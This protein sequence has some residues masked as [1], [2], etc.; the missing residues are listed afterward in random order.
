MTKQQK[1]PTRAD[2]ER[3]MHN[4]V[5]LVPRD[6]DTKSIYFDDKGLRLTVTS[7]YAVIGTLFH[8][9][10]FNALT[11]SG[12]SRP[13]LYTKNFIDIVLKNEND[14]IVKDEK[15]NVRRSYAKLFALLKEQEN[16]TDY[17]IC[18]FYDLWLTNIFSPLYGIGETES[19]AF[20]VY[21]RYLRNVA[22]NQV[23]LSEKVNGMTNK[24]FIKETDDLVAK[25]IG[26]M[27]ETEIF[28]P[29]T[30]DEKAKA[31][32]AALSEHQANETMEEQANGE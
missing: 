29:M 24:Q 14:I 28:K 23:I 1:K 2:I 18:W 26:D 12:I 22:R 16:K 31:E 30:D 10:V 8:R 11:A 27:K 25:Y 9:H 20:L 4:A 15:G 19:E 32:V 13:Y 21:E 7:D 6:K 3:R 17:N 5:V